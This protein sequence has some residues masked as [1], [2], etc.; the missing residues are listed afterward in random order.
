MS[1]EDESNEEFT[2]KGWKRGRGMGGRHGGSAG[3]GLGPGHGRGKRR[4]RGRPAVV[5]FVEGRWEPSEDEV[6]L[7][8]GS[9]E[10]E[11]LRLCDLDGLSQQEVADKL[12]VSRGSVFRYLQGARKKVIEAILSS[13]AI[14]VEVVDL[15]D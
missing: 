2:G 5:P 11:V 10:L 8:L 15:E 14:R 3:R 13:R 7:S 1:P 4:G 6:V 9:H 12:G